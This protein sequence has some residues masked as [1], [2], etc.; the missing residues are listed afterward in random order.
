MT[1][2]VRAEVHIQSPTGCPIAEVSE[3]TD[4][5]TT[6]ISKVGGDREDGITEE[7]ILDTKDKG[8]AVDLDGSKPDFEEVFTYRSGQ[9]FRFTRDP[10]TE[11]LCNCIEEHDCPI[12]DIQARRGTIVVVFH[13]ADMEQ[14]QA[15]LTDLT[16]RWS[17]V[18]VKRLLRSDGEDD[19]QDYVLLDRSELTDRQREV[20]EV[21]QEMDF[22][23]HGKGANAG[24]VAEALGISTSTFSEH[25]RA[26]QRKLF[27][28]II[29]E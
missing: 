4:S 23:E 27:Y 24:E 20:L 28:P 19:E 7:F 9:A 13:A 26:A 25:L 12:I 21:A 11:C 2:G 17:N 22:F 14:L 29:T 1:G 6:C 3:I 15:V 8:R 10:G 5:R 16:D 18:T